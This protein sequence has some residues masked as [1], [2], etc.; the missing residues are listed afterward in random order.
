MARRCRC[1]TVGESMITAEGTGQQQHQRN[2][3]A[4]SG[5]SPI[6]R[7]TSR[8]VSRTD[9]GCSSEQQQ[10]SLV[11]VR[12]L[13]V[14]RISNNLPNAEELSEVVNGPPRRPAAQRTKSLRQPSDCR[15]Q[16]HQ[17]RG[18]LFVSEPLVDR[19][20]AEIGPVSGR[21]QQQ[22]QRRQSWQPAGKG[23][24]AVMSTSCDPGICNV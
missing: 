6:I 1:F 9:D 23:T 15:R 19:E 7:F 17:Q 13:A 16:Q 8:V 20:T 2:S 24:T 10:P 11:V 3:G 4:R 22:Q 18:P 12:Q 21:R 5:G 14:S